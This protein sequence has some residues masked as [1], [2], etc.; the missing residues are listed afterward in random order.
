MSSN[1]HILDLD[2]IVEFPE[3]LELR[4]EQLAQRK[5]DLDMLKSPWYKHAERA[6]SVFYTDEFKG[7]NMTSFLAKALS[8]AYAMGAAGEQPKGHAGYPLGGW[9]TKGDV[10]RVTRQAIKP[11]TRATK[12]DP[13]DGPEP[14]PAPTR[15]VRRAVR[16]PAAEPTPAPTPA[17]ITRG[18]PAPA[19]AV[20][21]APTRIV[22]G[23]R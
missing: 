4:P 3:V 12:D 10:P 7:E 23:A 11:G 19:Q 15:Q 17:R 8:E 20:A 9:R 16:T 2:R 13:Q 14:E 18:R 6:L 22:R 1:Q 5:P 21:A